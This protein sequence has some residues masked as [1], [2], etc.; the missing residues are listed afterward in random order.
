MTKSRKTTVAFSIEQ[1]QEKDLK[2]LAGYTK[3]NVS[4]VVRSLLLSTEEVAAFIELQDYIDTIGEKSKE[5]VLDQIAKTRRLFFETV[6][7]GHIQ[8]P[9]ALQVRAVSHFDEDG[10]EIAKLFKKFIL[11]LQSKNGCRFGISKV[12]TDKAEYEYNIVLG[13]RE[14]IKDVESL[15]GKFCMIA[16]DAECL[17]T[18]KLTTKKRTNKRKTRK[19]S[20]RQ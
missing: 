2:R 18:I 14:K 10:T 6:M 1:E 16:D 9:I 4:E 20:K 7:S 15:I 3:K 13:N 8:A 19:L 5:N 17:E 11:A 12:K